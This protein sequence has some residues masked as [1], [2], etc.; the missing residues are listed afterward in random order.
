MRYF[1]LLLSVIFLPLFSDP[2]DPYQLA[3]TEG[4]P[5]TL[6]AG[7]VNAITGDLYL[8][9]EDAIVQGYIPLRLPRHYISGDGMGELAGWSFFEHLEA[10][11]KGGESEHQIKIRD[12]NGSSYTFRCPAGDVH[13]HL[14]KKSH[15]PK[16]RPP[17][18]EETPGMT[19]TAQGEISGRHNLKNAYIR[20]EEEG[21]SF[22][23]YCSDQTTKRYKIHHAHKHFK[24]V[25]KKEA[26]QKLIYLLQ[27]ETLPSGH[28]VIYHYDHEDRLDSIRTINPN[29]SKTY[30]SATFRYLHKHKRNGPDVD[31]ELSD[32]RTLR[33]RFEEKD[34]GKVY[35]LKS[36]ISPESPEETLYYQ[37]DGSHY[38]R[39]LCRTTEPHDRFIDID[40]YH[41]GHHDVG[42]A[43]VKVKDKHDPKFLRVKTLKAPVGSDATAHVTHRFFYD[44]GNRVT[45]V[46]DIDNVLTKYCY[47]SSMRLEAIL[48]FDHNDV[49]SQKETFEWSNSGELLSRS[50]YTPQGHLLASR[51]L[52]YDNRGNVTRE[53]L[54]GDLSGKGNPREVYTIQREYSQDGRDLLLKEQEQNGK[55]TQYTYVPNTNLLVAKL[56][57]EGSQI[58]A[59]TFYEYNNDHVL[60]KEIRDDGEAVNKDELAGVKTRMIKVITPM[61]NGPFV[62]MPH[63]IE[64]KFW[65]GHQEQL[66]KRTALSYTT[67]GKIAKEEIYDACEKFCYA[68][69][70]EYDHLGRLIQETKAQVESLTYAYDATGNKIAS[71]TPK[72]TGIISYNHSNLPTQ[73][74]ETGLDG[75]R[76]VTHYTYDGKNRKTSETSYL[77]NTTRYVYNGLNQIIETHLPDVL[78]E[79]AEP[80]TP[81]IFSSY[82][83]AGREI[84]H[85]DAKAHTTRTDYNAR[86]QVTRICY[87]DGTQEKFDYNLDGT[88]NTH[89]DQ[90]GF[91]TSHTYDCFGRRRST[92]DGNG[93]TTTYNYDGFQLT[94]IVDAENYV[95]NYSYDKAGR[96]IKEERAGEQIDYE[97]DPLNRPH[98]TKKADLLI[99]TEYDQLNRIIEERQ[100]DTHGRL[101]AKET[102]SYDGAGNRTSIIRYH[103]ENPT[104]DLFSYDTFDRLISHQ[105]PLGCQTN[106][107]YDE[108]YLNSLGQRVL[109]TITTDPLNR[110]TLE[111]HDSVGRLTTIETRSAQGSTCSLEEKYYDLNNNL[112]RQVSTLFPERTQREVNWRYDSLNRLVSLIEPLG[113]TTQY[114]YTANG[115]LK[116][117]LK[118]DGMM[119]HRD[120]D[121]SGNLITLASSDGTVQYLF[122]YNK[123]DQLCSSTDLNTQATTLLKLDPHGRVLTETLANN[124]TIHNRYDLFGR[125][126]ELILP[127]TST[128]A[129][130]YDPAHLR[131][132]TRYDRLGNRLYS[133]L[134]QEYDLSHHLLSQQLIGN[135]GTF[136]NTVNERGQ[137][138]STDTPYFSQQ[139]TTFDR[140]G[141]I[142][143]I[144]T[145]QHIQQYAYD[146]LNQ[147]IR[148][149]S[150]TYRYDSHFNRLEKDGND[151]NPNALDHLGQAQYDLNGNPIFYNNAVYAYDALDRLISI[152]TDDQ[153]LLFTYDSFHRRLSKSIF[154]K[155]DQTWELIDLHNYLY[156][157]QNEIGSTDLS[158]HIAELRI[159]GATPTAEIGAAVAIELNQQ[160]YAPISDLQGNIVT[161]VSLNGSVAERYQYSSFGEHMATTSL[162]NPWRFAS[163]RLDESGLIYFGRRYYD[164]HVGRWLNPDPIGFQ[165][166][167]NMYAFVQNN[168]LTHRDLYG[169]SVH[170]VS[171]PAVSPPSIQ[172]PSVAPPQVSRKQVA[173]NPL[174]EA[175]APSSS[176]QRSRSTVKAAAV[177]SSHAFVNL[178]VSTFQDIQDA[179]FLIGAD[180]LGIPI[181]E[182]S[183]M[184][185]AISEAHCAQIGSINLWTASA[186]SIDP[187]DPIYTSFRDQTSLALE[188][189]SLLAG[190]YGIAKGAMAF[191]KLAKAPAQVAKAVKLGSKPVLTR[192]RI[193]SYLSN[194]ESTSKNQI[195]SDIGSIGIKLKGKSP[196]GRF[197][198]FQDKFG[199]IRIKIHPPDKKTPYDHLHLYDKAGNPLNKH[200]EIVDRSSAEAHIPYGG[201]Q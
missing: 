196:D 136:T 39:L 52:Q 154:K 123:I 191:N 5:S 172:T 31:I 194:A 36:I 50:L 77:G 115:L 26:E 182:L 51:R 165:G 131:E 150:H 85:T 97:Y 23:V 190:G 86:S 178:A 188:V 99:I 73:L 41:I 181:L 48:R 163:K 10:K 146:D 186:F 55:T 84:L 148:E 47:S 101:L 125:R 130:S 132:V 175:Q 35:L 133:H 162:N 145:E 117:T 126:S 141:N 127:N 62:D 11:Y 60:T 187:F 27:S 189:G 72:R 110:Q 14:H 3:V 53:D 90:E 4:D 58:K 20:L 105:D 118:P 100:E 76:H 46:R 164:P 170:N 108:S 176:S 107:I 192:A 17:P 21:K 59:R 34:H 79:N 113:K 24:N 38:G 135:L 179:S 80:T 44:P 7:C 201:K 177:G 158:G 65:N 43:D 71:N 193:K 70:Y 111:T 33:Y 83:A 173:I 30:A 57:C 120:Y 142:C 159:L 37:P 122:A 124:L 144:K 112:S 161:L 137:N 151:N 119:L 88:L 128:I 109:Q 143:E 171:P 40:Y 87:P 102:Y 139:V 153:R 103:T 197:L 157:G 104:K 25:F 147:L 174:P 93:H 12:L 129:Y 106:I 66:L 155:A 96:K 1:F 6:V 45:D 2:K 8:D 91:V 56:E 54:Y 121:Q 167:I 42:G 64:E 168:P 200:L 95:T 61:P 114:T 98:I 89:I 138:T 78:N 116:E 49:L 29:G 166:G 63:I 74:E 69:T 32:G 16:F 169:L 15:P 18:P 198:H 184:I 9:E 140:V 68:L 149:D 82:D 22:T 92:T 195:I 183:S 19:N 134:Y 75:I 180:A 185:E 156:D 28:Q 81:V 13:R 160:I 67:G 199:N 152:E 94:S